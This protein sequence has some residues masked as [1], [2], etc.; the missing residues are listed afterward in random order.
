MQES[1]LHLGKQVSRTLDTGRPIL[2]VAAGIQLM[3][4]VM[5]GAMGR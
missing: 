4:F 1:L 2:L 5:G 3:A